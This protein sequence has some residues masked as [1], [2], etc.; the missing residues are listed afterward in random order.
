MI[1]PE[2][3]KANRCI[4]DICV[5]VFKICTVA[6]RVAADKGASRM[7]DHAKKQ[8]RCCASGTCALTG[9][10]ACHRTSRRKLLASA[11]CP[12]RTQHQLSAAPKTTLQ[13]C[14]EPIT[15]RKA[16]YAELLMG[17]G[18]WNAYARHQNCRAGLRSSRKP[19]AAP[20]VTRTSLV[21]LQLAF[22]VVHEP[23]LWVLV[24]PNRA[25]HF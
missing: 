17:S 6:S 13:N 9:A 20:T 11:A 10:R 7:A 1:A 25:P 19:Q 22:D 15:N 12:L 3:L 4:Y 8:R 5:F 24:F 21:A 23:H 2:P 18:L 16:W 14:N